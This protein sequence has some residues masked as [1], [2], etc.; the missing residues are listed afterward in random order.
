[1]ISRTRWPTTFSTTALLLGAI[2]GLTAGIVF[3]AGVGQWL[4]GAILGVVLLSITASRPDLALS[5][6]I[7]VL[8]LRG[9]VALASVPGLPDITIG[10]LLVAWCIVVLGLAIGRQRKSA[11]QANAEVGVA[12]D[13]LTIWVCVLLA[14]MLLAGLRNPS[15]QTGLQSW[16]DDYMLPFG[17]LLVVVRYQWPPRQINVVVAT[18]F[19]GCC[20]WSVLATIE[21]LTG[22]SYF[23]PDGTLPWASSGSVLV[24]T[25]GPFINPAFLG[26]A[27]GIGLV[28]A[29]V[30]AGRSGVSKRL[31]IACIPFAMI[32]LAV[33]L[34]RASWL[35]AAAG[36]LVVIAGSRQ[37]RVVTAVVAAAGLTIGAVIIV[38]LFGASLVESRATSASEVYSRIVVQRAA[39]S[40]VSDHPILGVGSGRFASLSGNDLRN[41]G[42]ISGSF[43][44]GILV[45][46]NTILSTSVD[47]GLGAGVA[48]LVAFGFLLAG[49]RRLSS[50]P[51]V[52]YLGVAVFGC[53]AVFAINAM[54][55]DIFL[56]GVLATLALVMMGMLASP[57]VPS[58]DAV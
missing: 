5:S 37:G 21:S 33:A 16:V 52:H 31:A 49:A 46:H 3:A 58:G 45:P 48:L 13:S 30:W 8:P 39:V 40:I 51:E 55:I 41:V 54:F 38:S 26:T 24:R 10:R 34:T 19:S 7:L 25:G 53:I 12:R 27:L 4:V 9:T 44:V 15:A 56:G 6:L 14:L 47:G 32:G 42:G 23:A 22:R 20:L 50:L 18:Y 57:L 36:V 35:G 11:Q 17:A 28:L 2:V 29:W 43:G 1:M